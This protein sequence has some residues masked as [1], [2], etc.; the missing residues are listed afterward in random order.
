MPKLNT[1]GMA[2]AFAGV[3][4]VLMLPQHNPLESQTEYFSNALE[5]LKFAD[6]PRDIAG[7]DFGIQTLWRHLHRAVKG[8]VAIRGKNTHLTHSFCRRLRKSG[9]EIP[10]GW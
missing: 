10:S 4:T 1:E 2:V 9:R 3:R 8:A 6:F 5:A 7:L